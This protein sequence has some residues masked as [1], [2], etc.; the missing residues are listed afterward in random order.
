MN[1]FFND[2]FENTI[3]IAEAAKKAENLRFVGTITTTKGQT[4]AFF[5]DPSLKTYETFET[6]TGFIK[7]NRFLSK[8]G[9]NQTLAS[10]RQSITDGKSVQDVVEEIAELSRAM[11]AIQSRIDTTDN[12]KEQAVA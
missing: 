9:I 7:A 12:V 1:S 3:S 6:A 8:T 11:A 4:M 2:D 5:Q 10:Y